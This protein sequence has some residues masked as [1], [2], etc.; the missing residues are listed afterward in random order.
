MRYS[1]KSIRSYVSSF[2]ESLKQRT[3]LAGRS[4]KGG[5]PV[6]KRALRR[7]DVVSVSPPRVFIGNAR[8]FGRDEV[9]VAASE[10]ASTSLFDKD[11][12]IKNAQFEYHLDTRV[13]RV[14][15]LS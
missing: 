13:L 15:S 12:I 7:E 11:Y 6:K 5:D 9:D 3:G 4:A 10:F 2:I 1:M 8:Q 14:H